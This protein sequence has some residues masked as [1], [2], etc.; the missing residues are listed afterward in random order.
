MSILKVIPGFDFNANQIF[1]KAKELNAFERLPYQDDFAFYQNNF[2]IYR[3]MSLT[4]MY[5]Y[6]I[7][8]V[9]GVPFM[10]QS[11]TACSFDH[12]G[13]LRTSIEEITPS[14]AYVKERF[15]QDELFDSCFEQL[16]EYKNGDMMLDAEGQ[17]IFQKT[18][19]ELVA[20]AAYGARLNL[21]MGQVFDPAAVTFR[22]QIGDNVPTATIQD[23]FTRTHTTSKGWVK[24]FADLAV[25]Y[26]WLNLA[27]LL[28][29]TSFTGEDFTGDVLDFY[30]NLK[31]NAPRELKSLV[32][33]GG[34]ARGGS[35]AF[36]PLF[37]VS[38]SIHAAVVKQYI[39]QRTEAALNEGGRISRETVANGDSMPQV[40]YHIDGMIPVIPISDISEY[41]KY[42]N[43]TTH[44]GGIVASGN[45]QLG[46]SFG[47]INN[48]EDGIAMIIE[49]NKSISN[50]A[51][52]GAYH[53][54]SV[55]LFAS[56][57]AD[58][59]Y[60]VAARTFTPAPSN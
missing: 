19:E 18:I 58:P 10:W 23:L 4:S 12:T 7:T 52:Y 36:K 39:S 54:Q 28:P 22:E 17:R 48:V 5:T 21:T 37:L 3:H 27:N 57:L 9:R 2:G 29:S 32:N 41:D 51:P 34:V 59:N 44:F 38:D 53:F 40:V 24:L 14:R 49:Q 47:P 15:C 6:K 60:A 13:S 45:I 8:R 20:N 25:H 33:R 55:G 46:N 42:L 16:I 35:A 50:D 43:G 1:Y 30:D 31:D 11:L 26:P 56:A